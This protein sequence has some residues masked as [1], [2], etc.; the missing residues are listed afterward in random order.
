MR[1]LALFS[2]LLLLFVPAAAANGTSVTVR[3]GYFQP[4]DSDFKSIYGG[5]TCWG[6]EGSSAVWKSLELWVSADLVYKKGHLIP[7]GEQTKLWLVPAG[8]GLRVV[9]PAGIF[10]LFAGVGVLYHVF[11]EVNPIGDVTYGRWGPAVEAGGQFPLQTKWFVDLHLQYSTCRMTPV[12]LSFNV[13]GFQAAI[14]IGYR[15]K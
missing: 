12:E 4:S 11:R 2:I 5:G 15:F 1:K 7:T 14:G 9:R 6:I 8:G 3:G 10:R 13:G